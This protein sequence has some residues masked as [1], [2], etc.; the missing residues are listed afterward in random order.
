MTKVLKN[1]VCCLFEVE[2]EFVV[3]TRKENHE[4]WGMPGGKVDAGESFEDAIQREI[5]EELGINCDRTLFIPI[6]SGVAIGEVNYW[7]TTYLYLGEIDILKIN[8]EQGI[9]AGVMTD[10]DLCDAELSPFWSYNCR[11]FEAYDNLKTVVKR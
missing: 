10:I 6:Y 4:K 7:V 2:K 3:V 5:F 8:P 9:L 1:A 11:M